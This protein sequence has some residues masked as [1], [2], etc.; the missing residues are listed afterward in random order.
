[1]E[2][3][4]TTLRLYTT[5]RERTCVS[6]SLSLCRGPSSPSKAPLS[7]QG[8][9]P[10]NC[11]E[12]GPAQTAKQGQADKF[13]LTDFKETLKALDDSSEIRWLTEL[14]PLCSEC[15]AFMSMG[16]QQGTK[17]KTNFH[18]HAESLY[19]LP[20]SPRIQITRKRRRCAE[21]LVNSGNLHH[22]LKMTPRTPWVT[23]K[24][25]RLTKLQ[26]TSSPTFGE[27]DSEE[28]RPIMCT[29]AARRKRVTGKERTDKRASTEVLKPAWREKLPDASSAN[30]PLSYSKKGPF[31]HR[32]DLPV[33]DECAVAD[34]D[35]D[36]SEYDNETYS[37]YISQSSLDPTRETE[38]STR[39]SAKAQITQKLENKK[40]EVG[41]VKSPQWWFEELGKR[42]AAQR[43]IGKIEEVE[44]II[45]RVSLTSSDLIKEGSEGDN[46]HQ[47]I[48]DGCAGEDQL[49]RC[50][51]EL[52]TDSQMETQNKRCDAD[53]PL[54]VEELRVL[55]EALSQSLHQALRMEETKAEI[56]AFIEDKQTF[57]D[58]NPTRSERRPLNPPSHPYY[59]SDISSPSLPAGGETSPIPS[60]PL[61]TVLDVSPRASSSFEGMSPILSPL[62]SSTLSSPR[63]SRYSLPLNPTDWH[64]GD[65]SGN[66]E[67]W[68]NSVE[69]SFFSQGSGGCG[70]TTTE[71]DWMNIKRKLA[72]MNLGLSEENQMQTCRC[73]ETEASQDN[74]LSSDE[75]L[76]R[77][78]EI[79]Q[80]EVE[81]SLSFCRSFNHP[82]RPKHV[83]FL[84]ITAPEDDIIDSPAPTPLPIGFR[85]YLP[86]VSSGC[87]VLPSVL[88]GFL[89]LTAHGS[90]RVLSEAV[91]EEA[92]CSQ[93]HRDNLQDVVQDAA[94]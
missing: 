92:I 84:R 23:L 93:L 91:A 32:K 72:W 48:P 15:Q 31:S 87:G 44:G 2:S 30:F 78:E 11:E 18:S 61:S 9:L 50:R 26:I 86:S 94:R 40:A 90:V 79:W 88:G 36:L 64:E 59:F 22:N 14:L 16:N 19:A 35:T 71:K 39:N 45:R 63:P 21:E 65:I 42:A 75:A 83:D 62:F 74:L 77:Q 89:C 57:H 24:S 38:E 49:Q 43:V 67:E 70:S 47:F 60:L 55:G 73:N 41:E 37:M 34:S 76:R 85:A 4:H 56:E 3:T 10:P 69:S 7:F 1:M 29:P 46:E 52:S 8:R 13:G 81:E 6:P 20:K 51:P 68:T 28:D 17:L 58:Q 27:W 33:K 53:K 5:I 80:Q 54:L 82:S 66:Q 25:R 12:E